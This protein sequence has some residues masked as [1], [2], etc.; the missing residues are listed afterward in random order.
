[1]ALKAKAMSLS[2]SVIPRPCPV[3]ANA[4]QVHDRKCASVTCSVLS[5]A[6]QPHGL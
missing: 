1:M 3:L 2:I 6:L 5:D 4:Q